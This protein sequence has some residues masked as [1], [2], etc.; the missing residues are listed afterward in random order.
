MRGKRARHLKTREALTT[1]ASRV[2]YAR[3]RG[4]HIYIVVQSKIA[5][6][7]EGSNAETSAYLNR[8]FLASKNNFI[9]YDITDAN[10]G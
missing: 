9:L 5:Y 6:P 1:R 2:Q 3:Q 8:T 7:D 4:K 10:N